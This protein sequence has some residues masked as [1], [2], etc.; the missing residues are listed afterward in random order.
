M[1]VMRENPKT[2]Q[3][4]V[5]SVLAEQ[6]LLE[7]FQLM[8]NDKDNPKGRTEEPMEIDHIRPQRNCLCHKGHTFGKTLESRS[9]NAIAQVREPEPGEV[10][11]WRCGEVGHLKRTTQRT[12]DISISNA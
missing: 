11:C 3:A 8:S 2:F 1:K 6:N 7:R 9:V 10:Y 12:A 4:T 5:Q